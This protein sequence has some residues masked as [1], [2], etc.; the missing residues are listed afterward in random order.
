VLYAGRIVG[1]L[2]AGSLTENEI[3]RAALGGETAEKAA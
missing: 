1:E 2:D 3:M